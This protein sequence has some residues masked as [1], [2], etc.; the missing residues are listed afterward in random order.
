MRSSSTSQ[1]IR[2]QKGKQNK[3]EVN[4]NLLI[5]M[6]LLIRSDPQIKVLI[7]SSDKN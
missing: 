4:S 3:A 5:S 1:V 7:N 6:S 2:I